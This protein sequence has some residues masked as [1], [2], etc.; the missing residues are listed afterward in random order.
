MIHAMEKQPSR[1]RGRPR[2][3]PADR[4]GDPREEILDVAARLFAAHGYA[5]TGTREIAEQAG[6]RQP[7][8]F[9][10][11]PR[12]EDILV[13]LLDRTVTPALVG[14]AWLTAGRGSPEVRLYLLARHDVEN[15]CG[16]TRNLA[17]LQL[18]PEARDVRF[19]EFWKKRDELRRRYRTF[20]RA[21]AR[22]GLLV[23]LPV[24]VATNLVFGAV[25]ASM[26]WYD[27]SSRLTARDISDAVATS[28]VRGVLAKP[29]A[30]SRLRAAGDRML[31]TSG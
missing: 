18:L 1:R 17:A 12:K 27:G 23:D 11:F 24:E 21:I 15:L 19:A 20:V 4:A 14:T 16:S 5:A 6:L 8:L 13:E 31:Q 22:A 3:V 10:Y 7:S 2:A 9:H 26:T 29:P 28:A 30:V 25:E